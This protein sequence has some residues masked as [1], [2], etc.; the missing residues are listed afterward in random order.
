MQRIYEYVSSK[1]RCLN[2]FNGIVAIFGI[3]FLLLSKLSKKRNCVTF[4]ENLRDL[5][6]ADVSYLK[7]L[8]LISGTG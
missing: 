5:T 6:I 2:C 7:I 8:E 3:A 4:F 1:L